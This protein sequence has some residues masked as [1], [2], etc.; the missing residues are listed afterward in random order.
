MFIFAY[1][2]HM[3]MDLLKAIQIVSLTA[4]GMLALI[5]FFAGITTPRK[6]STYERSR[7][8]II[9]LMLL[10][11]FQYALQMYFGFRAQGSDAG[12]AV[13]LL[14]Y[15]P[16]TYL[17]ALSCI[18][19]MN[20]R[21]AFLRVSIIGIVATLLQV[22]NFTIGILVRD[23]LHL[24]PFLI[25]GNIIFVV[26]IAYCAFISI[27]GCRIIRNT[28]NRDS[29]NP[30]DAFLLYLVTG[31]T[32][33]TIAA[34]TCPVFIFSFKLLMVLGPITLVAFTFFVAS[35]CGLGHEYEAVTSI[36]I[37]AKSPIEE[38]T[39]EDN[40]EA[41]QSYEMLENAIKE[42]REKKGYKDQ[43]LTVT[44]F[45][46]EIGFNRRIVS[47]YFGSHLGC[48]FRSWIT[49]VRVEEAKEMISQNPEFKSEYVAE[50]CGFSS[51]S[52]FQTSFK[53]LTG[54]TP[55]EWAARQKNTFPNT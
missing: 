22:L 36:V 28:V 34:L 21:K 51:R 27:R 35:F 19:L 1:R 49:R 8:F 5:L 45:S 40:I 46:Q 54:I 6:N 37:D 53:N 2:K 32:L 16:V 42:W 24:G 3:K 39:V 55:M 50:E 52:F 9:S 20:D 43:N 38:E 7:W 17:T 30:A 11:A 23:S 15:T 25:S 29:G 4:T 48:T 47:S 44:S 10:L 33:V 26:G 12:A 18:N 13:N 31:I 41:N 14:F